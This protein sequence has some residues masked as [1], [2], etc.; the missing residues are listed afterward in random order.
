MGMMARGRPEESL[1]V[2]EILVEA[3]G[4]A[5]SDVIVNGY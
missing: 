3:A 1:A 4:V 5:G 2:G